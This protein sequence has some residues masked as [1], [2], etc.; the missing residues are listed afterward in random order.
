[1][2]NKT[3]ELSQYGFIKI[4]IVLFLTAIALIAFFY[5]RSVSV[6]NTSIYKTLEL[7]SKSTEKD[8][9]E[10]KSINE[11]L[12][13][14]RNNAIVKAIKKTGPSV[15]NISAIQVKEVI[16]PWFDLFSIGPLY[17]E[18]RKYSSLGSGVIIDSE[19]YIVTNE[20]V[21]EDADSIKVT[22]SD[23]REMEA[24]LVGE[25]YQS[26]IAVLKVDDE[27]LQEA[28]LGE[29]NNLLIGEWVVA[30]GNPFGF[31][32]K[33]PKPT[34]TIGIISALDRAVEKDGR[35][36]YNLIQTD[37]SINPGNS[38]GALINALGQVIG[39]NTMIYSTSGG[40]QG[41]G[42]AVPI[43]E[44]KKIIQKLTKYGKVLLPKIGLEYQELE[45]EIVEHF[46]LD[47]NSGVLVSYVEKDSQA[48]AAGFRR[49]D[50]IQSIEGTIVD[51]VQE[52]ENIIRIFDV[53][54]K[55]RF[56]IIRDK[57][58]KKILVEVSELLRKYTVWGVTVEEQESEKDYSIKGVVV[59]DVARDSFLYG[60]NGLK[61]GDLI[62]A[63]NDEDS[64]KYRTYSIEDFR[65][66]TRL[67]SRN[68]QIVIYFQRNNH[69][70]ALRAIVR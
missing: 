70:Y 30:I 69:R 11:N 55:V 3:I 59:T 52:V 22:I 5:A 7:S 48:K 51:S 13:N 61:S 47:I 35:F 14:N 68:Q 38:G 26:D 41:I 34:A 60:K 33:D 31:A 50:I 63:I 44:S 53:G 15:V 20:H 40:S 66:L 1:M 9:S 62:Y 39:F 49:R 4:A 57:K 46:E 56:D 27:N 8:F 17:R 12:T 18:R 19:G 43:D 67:I 28:A 58:E 42:F 2:R 36:Y 45:P 6:E 10:I 21:I 64:R 25:D 29:S 32:V 54:D 16:D 65:N 23:G 37:A 24:I